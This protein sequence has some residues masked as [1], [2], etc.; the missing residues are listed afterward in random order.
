VFR[1]TTSSAA[2]LRIAQSKPSLS[3]LRAVLFDLDHTLF[4][5]DRAERIALR[6]ALRSLYLPYSPAILE[7]YRTINQELWTAYQRGEVSPPVLQRERFRRLLVHLGEGAHQ[8]AALALRYLE[9]LS[10]RGDLQAGCRS[11]LRG[12]SRQFLL[13]AV[14]NGIDR[15]QR[16]RL[17]SSRIETFFDT[18][19]TSE[20]CGFAK[21]DPRI[22][23]S[24]LESLDVPAE[25]ALLVGDD[26]ESDG[27]AAAR[28]GVRF[29]WVD[30]GKPLRRGVRRPKLRITDLTQL[31][32][33]VG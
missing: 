15:V 22:V 17:R 24:A 13:A 16:T 5:T 29:C 3:Q 6:G 28:A 21:P 9:H 32:G 23:C 31:L 1:L 4:D 30:G 20:A 8:T 11:T 12:L 26:P 25:D 14:T 10:A 19:V 2:S 18:V 7:A 33:V 27:L